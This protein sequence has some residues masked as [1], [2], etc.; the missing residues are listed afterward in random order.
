MKPSRSQFITIRGLRHHVRH[1]GREGA[2]KVFMIHGWMDVSASFQFLVDAMAGDW[3]VIAPDWRG[4]GLTQHGQNDT[5]WYTDC[6]GDLD[7]L[8]HHFQPQETEGPVRIVAHSFGASVSC[9]YA[10]LKPQRIARLVNIDAYGPKPG[11]S[12]EKFKLYRRWFRRL[13]HR[14]PAPTY[15]NWEELERRL[16][17][18]HPRIPDERI[19]FIA[20]NWAREENGRV[21][22]EHDPAHSL[23]DGMELSV[24][25]ADALAAWRAV[26]APVLILLA[27]QG[28]AVN[29]AP[30][31][32]PGATAEDRFGS[33]RNSR[34]VWFE[35]TGHMMHL[36][37]PAELAPIIEDFLVNGLTGSN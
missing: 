23:N 5:Y 8:L 24:N 34:R 14:M 21:V 36:E 10:G 17:R 9:F 16:K 13:E 15:A 1:W 27:R 26:T 29:R 35:D 31:L 18:A 19:G 20:R 33:F 3:H 11:G 7:Q 28:G 4:Y 32:V 2:P 25:M 37:R 30:D 6:L 12:E 22:L